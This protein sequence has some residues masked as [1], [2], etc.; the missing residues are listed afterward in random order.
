M[1]VELIKMKICVILRQCFLLF[2]LATQ[3]SSAIKGTSS[4]KE[5]KERGK[6]KQTLTCVVCVCLNGTLLC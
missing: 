6:E 1:P 4:T 5:A 3:R 2:F